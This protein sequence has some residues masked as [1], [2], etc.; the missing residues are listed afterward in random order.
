MTDGNDAT[1][2]ARPTSESAPTESR[3]GV[4]RPEP[5]EIDRLLA[6][7]RAYPLGIDYLM[8]GYLGSVAATFGVHA[9]VVEEARRQARRDAPDKKGDR[10]G[11]P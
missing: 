9:F 8:K 4:F 11:L 3:P 10:D 7:A 1:S 6:A 5:S 2:P